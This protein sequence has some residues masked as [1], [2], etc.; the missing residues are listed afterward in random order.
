VKIALTGAT[1]FIGRHVLAQLKAHSAH[2]LVIVSRQDHVDGL[3]KLGYKWVK[4]NI[5]DAP[6]DA[7]ERIGRPDVLIHMAWGGLPNYASLHH[8]ERELP[9]QYQFLNS[10]IRSG[11]K[12]VVVTGT[13]FEYGIQ[14]GSLAEDVLTMPTNPYGF[15]KD[16]LRKQ[17]EYLQCEQKFQLVWVR[18][19]YLYGDGQAANSLLPQLRRAVGKRDAYFNMSEGEQ[20]RDYMPVENAAKCIASLAV[21]DNAPAIINVCSGKPV[22][23]RSMVE[24]WLHK[25]GWEIKLN[26]G[27]YPYSAH[28]PMAFWGDCRTLNKYLKTHNTDKEVIIL[29]ERNKGNL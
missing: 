9:S 12:K 22:S 15:A 14:N 11:L 19:F 26:L 13:C 24:Q 16:A 27:Y 7:F 1:G 4:M 20:L 18:M 17:L 29:N 2:D 21:S 28:E 23:V 5:E 8:F 3:K 25:F 6:A 10:L